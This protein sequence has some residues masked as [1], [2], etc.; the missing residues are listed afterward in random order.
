MNFG[1]YNLLLLLFYLINSFDAFRIPSS[2]NEI[3]KLNEKQKRKKD[4]Y[5]FIAIYIK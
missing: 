4:E 3:S 2:S 1:F 5:K